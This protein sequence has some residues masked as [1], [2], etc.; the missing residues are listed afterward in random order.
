[1]NEEKKNFG[2]TLGRTAILFGKIVEAQLE[3]ANIDL[4]IQQLM[5]LSV[6]TTKDHLIQQDLADFMK[7]DKS[8]VLRAIDVLEQR[9]II[10][11]TSDADDRRKKII[12]ITRSGLALLEQARIVEQEVI[13]K[14]QAGIPEADLA[15]FYR[16]SNLL[17]QNACKQV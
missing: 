1:M 3:A 13:T 15:T 7:K 17:Q 4:N 10:A 12:Q 16:V 5:L 6:L 9:K 14:L 2:M 8:A 11:R